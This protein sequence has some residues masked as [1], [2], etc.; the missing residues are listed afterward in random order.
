MQQNQIFRLNFAK[1]TPVNKSILRRLANSYEAYERFPFEQRYKRF[2]ETKE[3]FL[4]NMQEDEIMT[5]FHLFVFFHFASSHKAYPKISKQ[6]I[7]E[8][9]ERRKKDG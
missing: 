5:K 4:E 6:E 8:Y 7:I 1:K 2:R 9:Y 3:Y